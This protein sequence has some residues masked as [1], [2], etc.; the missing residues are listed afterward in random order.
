M[1]CPSLRG[2]W[3]GLGWVS[4]GGRRGPTSA[5]GAAALVSLAGTPC[6][7]RSGAPFQMLL[8]PSM[9]VP[10]PAP[11]TVTLT[12]SSNKDPGPMP[13]SYTTGVCVCALYA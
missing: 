6:D 1:G 7:L 5:D 3:L 2:Q 9:L 8:Q 10:H 4:C 12:L 11:T 13:A